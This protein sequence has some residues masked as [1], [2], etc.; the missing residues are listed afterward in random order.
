VCFNVYEV[1]DRDRERH[2]ELGVGFDSVPQFPRTPRLA[3]QQAPTHQ[4]PHSPSP[5]LHISTAIS[6]SAIPQD[7]NTFSFNWP[8]CKRKGKHEHRPDS[9]DRQR[10]WNPRN[11]SGQAHFTVKMPVRNK[12]GRSARLLILYSV[13]VVNI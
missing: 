7:S 9:T 6:C 2:R 12:G 8:S 10:S 5:I 11:D 3:N 13:P 4:I 1:R